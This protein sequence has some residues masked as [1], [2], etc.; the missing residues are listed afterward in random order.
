MGGRRE[1]IA[2]VS[3]DE[4][5]RKPCID[6]KAIAHVGTEQSTVTRAFV[7]ASVQVEVDGNWIE[8]LV[9]P[10]DAS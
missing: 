5:G 1:D 10:D 3:L 7:E 8:R 6:L 9:V 4:A 2:P